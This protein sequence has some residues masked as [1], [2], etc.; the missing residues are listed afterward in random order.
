MPTGLEKPLNMSVAGM[1]AALG[2]AN[3]PNTLARRRAARKANAA[4]RG[5]EAL[6]RAAAKLRLQRMRQSVARQSAARRQAPVN[7]NTH[8]N[9]LIKKANALYNSA[10]VNKGGLISENKQRKL[11]EYAKLRKQIMKILERNNKTK[12]MTSI[13]INISRKKNKYY[14]EG[15]NAANKT[16]R[17]NTWRGLIASEIG[18]G[19]KL[20]EPF[21]GV[22]SLSPSRRIPSTPSFIVANRAEYNRL[23]RLAAAIR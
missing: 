6:R 12:F 20:P 3:S 11:N 5:R 14:L 19:P 10:K 22:V 18:A 15:I 16:G 13:L 2:G 1:W 21:K 9:S 8:L 23:M 4:Q 17:W 7:I